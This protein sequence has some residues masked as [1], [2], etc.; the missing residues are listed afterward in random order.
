[1]RN[2]HDELSIITSRTYKLQINEKIYAKRE[3]KKQT[4]IC[5]AAII[6]RPEEQSKAL[7]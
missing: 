2:P 1:V 7:K 6:K 5:T 3:R 4:I